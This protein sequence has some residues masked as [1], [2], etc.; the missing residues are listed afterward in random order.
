MD[1]E[2]ILKQALIASAL[3]LLLLAVATPLS[4]SVPTPIYD[5]TR[6]TIPGNLPWYSIVVFGDNRPVDEMAV[7]QP[8][9]FYQLINELENI[10]PLAVIGLGDHVGYG[11]PQQYEKLYSI[12]NKTRLENLWLAPGN[13][14]VQYAGLTYWRQYVGADTIIVDDIPGWRI[15]LVNSEADQNTWRV[16]LEQAYTDLGNRQLI[17]GYHRPLY[18]NVQH[19]LKPGYDNILLSVMNT[20]GWPKI[21]LQAHFHAWVKYAVNGTEFLIT[22]G[23]GAP[24][25]S[26]SNVIDPDAECV[27][28]Y[29]YL[30]LKLYPNGSYAYWTVKLGEG[31]GTV[32]VIPLN[33]TAYSVVNS[34]VDVYGNPVKIPVRLKFKLGSATVY[35]VADIPPS[36][37]MVFNLDPAKATLMLST[38]TSY[39]VYIVKEGLAEPIVLTGYATVLNLSQYVAPGSVS[40]ETPAAIVR[41]E[42]VT[43]TQIALVTRTVTSTVEKTTTSTQYLTTT[44]T[45][46]TT[47]KVT[48]TVTRAIAET[49]TTTLR[50]TTTVTT[51]T[52]VPTTIREVDVGTTAVVGAALLLV[53]LGI[54]F[55]IRR[56]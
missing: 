52:P 34:K 56:R 55:T 47:E 3:T 39:Y 36:T 30:I 17:L 43:T 16:Q 13:H 42:T 2:K 1:L 7:E 5:K 20:R 6:K 41:A 21:A 27:S 54:G 11:T 35:V 50:E 12:L 24:L 23:A 49:A 14:D 44:F 33:S 28:E 32:K 4:A 29:H 45:T 26:C 40:V 10:Y 38:N 48:E 18:P 8:E 37:S 15:A 31:S 19:N 51:T 46:T 9:V 53:G 22:A 25:Y